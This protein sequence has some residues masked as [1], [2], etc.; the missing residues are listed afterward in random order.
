MI[1]RFAITERDKELEKEE[2]ESDDQDHD[3]SKRI[4][5]PAA[6]ISGGGDTA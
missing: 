3:G 2:E 6:G 4:S 1:Y 5:S